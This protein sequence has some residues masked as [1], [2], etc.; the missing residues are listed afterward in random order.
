MRSTVKFTAG[1]VSAVVIGIVAASCGSGTTAPVIPTYSATLS[2]A[3]EVPPKT[4]TGTGTATFVDN[5][6]SID[7]TM[8]LTGMTNVVQSHIHG[9]APVGTNASVIF[10]LYIPQT[11][12]GTLSPIVAKGSITNSNNLNVSLD[13]LRTL[14]KN[15]NAYVNVH[16]SA[17]PGGEIR[18]QVSRSN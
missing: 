7:W 8:T 5:G 1:L 17:N 18:G 9:P 12:T 14:F 6:T 2:P 11:A 10:N 3:S 15:G 4:T 13:S 16:T